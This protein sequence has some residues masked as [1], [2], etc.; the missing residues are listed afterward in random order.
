GLDFAAVSKRERDARPTRLDT[1]EPL[2]ADYARRGHDV[3]QRRMQVA[4]MERQIGCSIAFFDRTAP[5]VVVGD[6]AGDR[7]AVE[8]GGGGKGD[9]AHAGP[10]PA[11]AVALPGVRARLYSA[12]DGGKALG[13]PVS[14][15]V[16]ADPARP[17]R[18]GEP[19]DTGADDRDGKGL[20][21]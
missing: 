15:R 9:S 14:G 6:L 17:R 5:G 2:A 7:V 4:A 12:A 21:H 16:E 18:R 3:G 11:P 20:A 10:D 1:H 8:R 13:L 19:A